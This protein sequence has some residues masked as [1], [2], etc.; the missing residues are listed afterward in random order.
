MEELMD[1]HNEQGSTVKS[2]NTAKDTLNDASS[3]RFASHSEDDTSSYHKDKKS[4][5][6]KKRN[7]KADDKYL[8]IMQKTESKAS[9]NASKSN[10]GSCVRRKKKTEQYKN[11]VI[12]DQYGV[13]EY[14]KDSEGYKKARKRQQ[15]RES[16]LRARDKRASKMENVESNLD[17]IKSKS[18]NL[19]KENLVL[20]AEKRQLQ[21]QVKNLLSIICSF[22]QNKRF[23][24]GEKDEISEFKSHDNIISTDAVNDVKESAEIDFDISDSNSVNMSPRGASPE[25]TMLKL[26]RKD[27]DSI[28]NQEDNSYGDLFQK[29]MML[30]LTIVM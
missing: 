9:S 1:S 21:D 15:N 14:D 8:D 22:G 7:M 4:N 24:T 25:K 28:F 18:T 6:S 26:M 20:K 5:C 29:G 17:D 19:E 3:S 10:N 2:G 30:S 11:Q 23:K 27:Q 16:A 13:F 12:I